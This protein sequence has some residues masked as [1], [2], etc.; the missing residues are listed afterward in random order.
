MRL[1]LVI[2]A[3]TAL[4]AC[5]SNDRAEPVSTTN[6][7]TP[8]PSSTVR[9]TVDLGAPVGAECFSQV[10]VAAP[11]TAVGI[12][13]DGR[14]VGNLLAPTP[15]GATHAFVWSDGTLTQLP[16]LGGEATFALG[17]N[18][19]GDV[20]GVGTRAGETGAP[21][22]AVL[23][24][25]GRPIDLGD[26]GGGWSTAAHV[27]DAGDVAG[28]S[29]AA[30]GTNHA[31]LWKTGQL[32]SIAAAA[33]DAI[34]AKDQVLAHG[35]DGAVLWDGGT[36]TGLGAADFAALDG[37]G[38]VLLGKDGQASFWAGGATTEFHPYA[39]ETDVAPSALTASGIVLGS[40]TWMS[41]VVVG[42][43]W[44]D[45]IIH[46][47]GPAFQ[48]TAVNAKLEVAGSVGLQAAAWK[49][50]KTVLLSAATPAGAYAT[51]VNDD[52]VVVGVVDQVVKRWSTSACFE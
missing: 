41:G 3:A 17:M 19:R 12:A 26:L 39:D 4:A 23:W 33:S 42:F 51:A 47:L 34:N 48:P 21:G 38:R 25:N 16:G 13:S 50:G 37:S 29:S 49:G 10:T 32:Q 36:L 22:H 28:I 24:R 14:V 35:A 2:A 7:T 8:A 18:A 1:P 11:A 52:G 5:G 46:T 9:P 27:N 44:R 43:L 15:G 30:D 40:A 45:G 20:V 31:F 6:G